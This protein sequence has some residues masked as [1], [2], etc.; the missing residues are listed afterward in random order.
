MIFLEVEGMKLFEEL[1]RSKNIRY[2][3]I[4]R[5]VSVLVLNPPPNMSKDE[6]ILFQNTFGIVPIKYLKRSPSSEPYSLLVSGSQDEV[7]KVQERYF[8]SMAYWINF[9]SRQS[10]SIYDYVL[11]QCTNCCKWG[12]TSFQCASQAKCMRC[13]GPHNTINCSTLGSVKCASCLGNHE[14]YRRTC[15]ATVSY[16]RMAKP[17]DYNSWFKRKVEKVDGSNMGENGLQGEDKLR[18]NSFQVEDEVKEE[19]EILKE[20]VDNLNKKLEEKDKIICDLLNMVA[21]VKKTENSKQVDEVKKRMNLIIRRM[22]CHRMARLE[23]WVGMLMVGIKV[24]VA[25]YFKMFNVNDN[26]LTSLVLSENICLAGRLDDADVIC[27][28]E[29]GNMNLV[30][31]GDMIS[32]TSMP[33][34]GLVIHNNIVFSGGLQSYV[35]K[36]F[37]P[38]L[39]FQVKHEYFAVQLIVIEGMGDSYRLSGRWIMANFYVAPRRLTWS[40]NNREE[41]FKTWDPDIIV[42]D[43]NS[44]GLSGFSHWEE[45]YI[46]HLTPFPWLHNFTKSVHSFL[47]VICKKELNIQVRVLG[48]FLEQLRMGLDL[49]IFELGIMD[50]KSRVVWNVSIRRHRP[51]KTA[52]SFYRN[53]RIAEAGGNE[54]LWGR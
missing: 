37:R 25:K 47:D 21:L 10:E 48:Q 53:A 30:I 29:T 14:A 11:T 22:G 15:T 17:G 32:F 35:H 19:L 34:G 12:H 27:F 40:K 7:D 51:S 24:V 13:G 4:S 16:W 18:R 3:N 20:R 6:F 46:F 9:V 39:L 36:R 1:L 52:R 50:L 54:G 43:L 49:I 33:S 26:L 42:G 38:E 23:R 31:R 8:G 44:N 2:K 28:Q 5:K 41:W 45:E